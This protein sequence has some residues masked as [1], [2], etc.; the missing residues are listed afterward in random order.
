MINRISAKEKFQALGRLVGGRKKA[1]TLLG[2]P[3]SSFLQ[4]TKGRPASL[5]LIKLLDIHLL[6]ASQSIG[7]QLQEF[8]NGNEI[9]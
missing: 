4:Y 8:I 5:N 6:Y 7:H 1:A 3:F 9:S 2:V